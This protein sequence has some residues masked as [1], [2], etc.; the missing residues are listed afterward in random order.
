MTDA[1]LSSISR[2]LP[3]ALAEWSCC[4]EAVRPL[5]SIE[6]FEGAFLVVDISGF[7][8]VAGRLSR[9][10]EA[11]VE[12]ISEILTDFFTNLVALVEG[13]GGVVFGFEGDALLAAWRRD[14]DPLLPSLLLRCC[15]CALAI[16]RRFKDWKVDD[17]KLLMRMSIGAG[18][19][20]LMHLGD[21]AGRCHL[22]PAGEAV[23]QAASLIAFADGDEILVSSEAWPLVDERCEAEPFKDGAMRLLQ[24]SADLAPHTVSKQPSTTPSRDLSNYLP[25]AL[26]AGLNSSLPDW[27]GELRVVTVSFLKIE[28]GERPLGLADLN[29]VFQG[30]E[31]KIDDY[32]GEILE[33]ATNPNGL[34]V[35]CVFGLPSEVREKIGQRA[36]LAVMKITA[37]LGS[38]NLNVSAGIATGQVFCGPVG[39]EHRRQ[40][41]VVGAAVYLASRISSVAAGR[42]LVDEA[43]VLRTSRSILFSRPWPLHLAGIRDSVKG[44]VPLGTVD[45][46]ERLSSQEF[47]NR[48][49][50]IGVLDRLLRQVASGNTEVALIDGEPGMGKTALI[51]AFADKCAQAG[52]RRLEGAADALDQVTP[53]LAWR[54]IILQCL[55]LDASVSKASEV[56]KAVQRQLARSNELANLAPLLNDVLDLR[57][58]E[59]WLTSNMARDVRA[60][61]LRR[62]L[63]WIVTQRLARGQNLII[64]EDI[65]WVDES[66]SGLLIEVI[67]S[68]PAA[69][70]IISCR[71]LHDVQRLIRGFSAKAIGYR[72]LSLRPLSKKHTVDLACKRL[73]RKQISDWFA[74]LIVDTTEGNPFFVDEICHVINQEKRTSSQSDDPI[75]RDYAA[76]L[77]KVLETAVLSR[78]DHLPMDDQ[79]VAKLASVIGTTFR[80]DLLTSVAP[81]GLNVASSIERMLTYQVLKPWPGNI[82]GFAFRHHIIRDLVYA[83]LLTD[84]KRETHSALARILE[85]DSSSTDSVR[86]PLVL[87]HWRCA[88]NHKKM[89]SYLDQVA[90]L[91]LRQFD[92]ATAIKLLNECAALAREHDIE[93]ENEKWAVCHLLLGEAYVGSGRVAEA[94]KS[95]EIGLSLLGQALPKSTALLRASLF[96]QIVRQCW[97][98]LI[99]APST[100]TAASNPPRKASWQR[101]HIAAQ[102]Y[103]DLTRIYYLAGEKTR[104]LHAILKATNLAEGLRE[105]TPALAMNY[106]TLGAI[107]GVIPLKRQAEHYFYRASELA[108]LYNEPNVSSILHLTEGLY[109]TSIADWAQAKAHLLTGLEVAKAIGDKRRW[110]ELAITLETICSPWLLTPAFSNIQDWDALLN[111]IYQ[112]GRD[113]EDSHVLGCA[114]LAGLRGNRILGRTSQTRDRIEAMTELLRQEAFELELI[115]R[116]EGCAH[117]ASVEFAQGN[118]GAGDEWLQRC[119]GFLSELN[120]GLKVRTLPALAF[121]F[122]ACVQRMALTKRGTR[123][124]QELELASRALGKLNHFARIYPIGQPEKLRCQGDLCAMTGQVGKAVRLWQDSL[125]RA[126]RLKMALAAFQAAERLKRAGHDRKLSERETTADLLAPVDGW[127]DDVRGIAEHADRGGMPIEHLFSPVNASGHSHL[128]L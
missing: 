77:P 14:I 125:R 124:A 58:P 126:A 80:F 84:Q 38:E 90:A 19:I 32:G 18:E 59:N 5:P 76:K 4:A 96:W 107:C 98:R 36:I 33:V 108:E 69:L 8:K 89:I 122:Y 94:R 114:V 66:S 79:L 44:F 56:V 16:Q 74:Q 85:A 46:A 12:R 48:Q 43:T 29:H 103:E 121:L 119:E 49:R 60:E 3:G 34:E 99:G 26:R 67:R 116:V 64:L 53:Y 35:L 37:M 87:H 31:R 52:V 62:L 82:E 73:N 120:P 75:E 28:F 83:S 127:S 71:N 13:E 20:Q 21:D 47:I 23:E 9:R 91:R 25:R 118:I 95:Y 113:R 30:V 1:D 68:D 7:T 101:F 70:V 104:L 123:D 97:T 93:L 39:P 6:Y 22:L 92:N 109:R 100:E 88:D 61:N 11:G 54:A 40:Y 2:Y 50:E 117:L 110:C 81:K 111:E 115:H 65:Q 128:P 41:S 72:R 15:G 102:A 27:V 55:D 24:V 78:I 106:A 51:S 63:V 45:S 57:M 112:T 10:G 105:C 86:L 17:Q 42:I